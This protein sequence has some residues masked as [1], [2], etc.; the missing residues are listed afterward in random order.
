MGLIATELVDDRD[1]RVYPTFSRFSSWPDDQARAEGA[2]KDFFRLRKFS[3][4]P[5]S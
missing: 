1:E 2:P 4:A 5:T 3:F